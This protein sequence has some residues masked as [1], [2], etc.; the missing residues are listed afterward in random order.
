MKTVILPHHPSKATDWVDWVLT[1]PPSGWDEMLQDS[2]DELRDIQGT[3][4]EEVETYGEV[5]PRPHN[6]LKALYL[7]SLNSI[8]VVLVAQDPY[9]GS[10]AGY[11]E[12]RAQGLSFS[13]DRRDD[14]PGSL[15]NVY[16]ELARSIPGWQVPS[17]GCLEDWCRRGVLL[18]NASM[19]FC[20]GRKAH[21]A[22]L[23]TLGG[24]RIKNPCASHTPM[25][26]PL[27]RKV[28]ATI[29]EHRPKTVFLLVGKEAQDAIV[30]FL[31]GRTGVVSVSHP[32][33]AN[34]QG[35]FV[36]SNC[37]VQVNELLV[38]A[39]MEPIDWSLE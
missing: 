4:I 8:K 38:S 22:R 36:G 9:P 5:V 35:G 2:V 11:D 23:G 1:Y 19:T 10:L 24:G 25:W 16:K 6:Y 28:C 14:I 26:A 20:P 12:P 7:T 39:K 32:S 3:L 15:Q 30:P 18:L 31:G 34:T 21:F 37:F 17:H 33:M 29:L 13:V 27:V